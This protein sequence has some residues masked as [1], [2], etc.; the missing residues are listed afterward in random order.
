MFVF[1]TQSKE[2]ELEWKAQSE[3]FA[4][5]LAELEKGLTLKLEK[6]QE[7]IGKTGESKRFQDEIKKY[8]RDLWQLFLLV[9]GNIF[10]QNVHNK[11]KKLNL[12]VEMF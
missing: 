4:A 3:K 5:D 8:R 9:Q 11:I 1:K 7:R 6:Q 10:S 2:T 12:R